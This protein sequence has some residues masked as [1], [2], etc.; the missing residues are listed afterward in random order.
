VIIGEATQRIMSEISDY[1][2][3]VTASDMEEAVSLAYAAAVPG[4]IVLLS[5]GCASFDMYESYA[6]RGDI[7][8]QCV[9][10]IR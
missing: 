2:N 3:C 7:F 6:H 5:P 4:D 8:Q 1:V 9:K 10:A